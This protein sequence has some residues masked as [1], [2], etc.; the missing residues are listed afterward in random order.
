MV[1]LSERY[2]KDFEGLLTYLLLLGIIV[3]EERIWTNSLRHRIN[4][5]KK[6]QK[7]IPLSSFYTILSKLEKN[8]SLIQSSFVKNRK[9]YGPTKKGI[10][11]YNH[12]KEYFLRRTLIFREIFENLHRINLE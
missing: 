7:L 10:K 2:K 4:S 9:F 5:I 12:L 11:E 6:N 1:T 3:E 8:H